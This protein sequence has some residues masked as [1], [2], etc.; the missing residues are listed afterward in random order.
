MP[1]PQGKTA[2][3]TTLEKLH[4][5]ELPGAADMHVHLRDGEM[6]EMVA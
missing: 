2:S 3:A 4:G 5:V 6:K 1:S